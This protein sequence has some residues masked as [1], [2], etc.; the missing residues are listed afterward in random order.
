ML[1]LYK[2]TATIAFRGSLF[3]VNEF[4]FEPKPNIAVKCGE[5]LQ[6]CAE[7]VL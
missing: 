3:W 4:Q 5:V 7:L 6:V 2:E 1:L